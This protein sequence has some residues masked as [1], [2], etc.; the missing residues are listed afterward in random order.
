MASR[1]QKGVVL[2]VSAVAGVSAV[3]IG[4]RDRAE[5]PTRIG[6]RSVFFGV[7]A[8][9]APLSYSFDVENATQHP[10]T[11]SGVSKACGLRATLSGNGVILPGS[12]S[13]LTLSTHA[14]RMLG[15][16]SV[17]FALKQNGPELTRQMQYALSW[18]VDGDPALAA[19]EVWMDSTQRGTVR[20][21]WL[22]PP[23]A[24][25]ATVLE[26]SRG[27][28]AVVDG[29]GLR[30][31]ASTEVL[32]TS[33]WEGFVSISARGRVGRTRIDVPI[34]VQPRVA[35]PRL[36]T[37]FVCSVDGLVR[38]KIVGRTSRYL[39]VCTTDRSVVVRLAGGT[40]LVDA[41]SLPPGCAAPI[42]LQD[43]GQPVAVATLLRVG[44]T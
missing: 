41:R 25:D 29:S 1:L 17:C 12:K 33:R 11:V 44:R 6:P 2:T 10:M 19:S 20:I 35:E 39:R 18:V 32:A 27:L 23:K 30:L 3:F 8:P 22:I 9:E 15:Y 40:V 4:L 42:E 36:Y 38:L 34:F 5:A 31:T 26:A 13:H 37:A 21:P 7:V 24:R 16:Q 43:R 28:R 14:G